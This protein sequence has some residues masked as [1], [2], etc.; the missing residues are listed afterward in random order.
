MKIQLQNVT[1]S[2]KSPVINNLTC[3][4][5]AGKIYVIKGVSGCGKTTLL[6]LIGGID[7]KF[8]GNI[9]FDGGTLPEDSAYVF[10]SSLLLSNITVMENL[11]LIK[12][13]PD[14]INGL[15][16]LLHVRE[17]LMKY[18]QQLSG[19]ERQ[20]IAIVR[21]LLGSPKLFL[22]DEPTASLD[23]ENSSNIAEIIAG[24][25]D[26]GRIIIVATHEHYF[27]G[28]ADEIIHLSY[29]VIDRVDKST[30]AVIPLDEKKNGTS[31]GAKIR[32]NNFRY[33]L[34]RDPGLLRPHNL[35]LLALVF[36]IVMLVSTVQKN[37]SS[38]YERIMVKAYPADIITCNPSE[39]Q[40][41]P[42]K[43]D[44]MIY[45]DYI[46]CDGS[47]TAYHLLRKKDSVFSIKGMI[48]E[49][50][51]PESDREILV[52]QEFV[53]TRFGEDA[54]LKDCVEQTVTFKGLELVI[55]GITGNTEDADFGLNF[56]SD[57][58]YQ[59][60]TRIV[61][62]DLIF[63]PYDLLK[64]VGEK[65]DVGFVLAV[66]DDLSSHKDALHWL[67][68]NLISGNPNQ[69]YSRIK[70]AQTGLDGITKLFVVILFVS[71]IT[72]CLFM[73][74]IV[75]T[76]LFYRKKELGYL[77]I[78]G[79]SKKRIIGMVFSE[80]LLKILT[81]LG[82]S[83]VI[84]LLVIVG[85]SIFSG[86]FLWFDPAF[87]FAIAAALI[88]IYLLTAYLSIRHFLKKSIICLIT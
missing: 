32:F 45:D 75:Q 59:R 69:F 84:Y 13:A 51:Y 23:D 57:V 83:A 61:S 27:D 36:L 28:Y 78:F 3:S 65:Q 42:Y 82:V 48:A 85:Y 11:L 53:R 67:R 7:K 73:V 22:A 81:A 5:E 54:D 46:A 38:E 14:E 71:Y 24:L 21:A 58:Y 52:S 2:Y 63:V 31:S 80:Y 30:P 10:Q 39:L 6:N 64:T 60:N 50:K 56:N 34:K 74:S 62:D 43:D 88:G 87:T 15:C 86:I 19:G 35:F 49:G 76:E 33:A 68:E 25:R 37:L 20:R 66:Y 12:N 79:L 4:F 16:E 44:L 40:D 70:D 77:Q 17:L 26:P 55:S 18:P 47:V 29:G 8:E 9:F 1:K 72:S 41:F